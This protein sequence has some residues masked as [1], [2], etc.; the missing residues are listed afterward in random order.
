MRNI[1]R[2]ATYLV[3]LRSARSCARGVALVALC[4]VAAYAV[5]A[6]TWDESTQALAIAD[7]GDN[8]GVLIGLLGGALVMLLLVAAACGI[9]TRR[10]R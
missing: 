4:L 9:G 2:Q 8:R 10:P 5:G 3:H 6:A 1:D 7:P